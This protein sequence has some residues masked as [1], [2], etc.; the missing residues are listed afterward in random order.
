LPSWTNPEY[1]TYP[2]DI[3]DDVGEEVAASR[4]GGEYLLDFCLGGVGCHRY[5]EEEEEEEEDDDDDDEGDLGWRDGW[6]RWGKYGGW[7]TRVVAN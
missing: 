1:G 4:Q 6:I 7:D 5:C 2:V 3:V